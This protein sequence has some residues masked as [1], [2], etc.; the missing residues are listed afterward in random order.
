MTRLSSYILIVAAA[1]TAQSSSAFSIQPHSV[2]LLSSSAT[3]SSAVL[4]ATE[5][6]ASEDD[7]DDDESSSEPEAAAAPPVVPIA[8]PPPTPQKRLDPL[9]AS[10]TRT[11]QANSS[12]ETKNVPFFGEVAVDGGLTVLVPAAVIAVVGFIMSI[13]VALN[14][15]DTIVNNLTHLSD[16]VNAAALAKTNV[17]PDN[18][19]GCRGLCSSQDEQLESMRKVMQGFA[20]K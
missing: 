16:D 20:K 7:N 3:R 18:G 14:S 4:Y 9:V 5:G 12:G 11:D 6:A 8:M 17:V 19:G 10:V 1:M 13:V 2:A 15:S